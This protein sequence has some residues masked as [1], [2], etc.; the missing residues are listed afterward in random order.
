MIDG[1]TL[2]E[3]L[4]NMGL[5]AHGVE[6]RP[7]RDL[8]LSCRDAGS[9]VP[10]DFPFE[11]ASKEAGPG[12]VST[13]N[14]MI[15]SARLVTTRYAYRTFAPEVDQNL[16]ALA[17]RLGVGVGDEDTGLMEKLCHITGVLEEAADLLLAALV[18]AAVAPQTLVSHLALA[19]ITGAHGEAFFGVRELQV[20]LESDPELVGDLQPTSRS[21][22]GRDS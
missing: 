6:R 16:H 11:F 9:K 13:R 7:V 15:L 8:T 21:P 3:I 14:A 20:R 1:C 4:P 19:L 5:V 22:T 12:S 10:A 2:K 17:Q 18:V